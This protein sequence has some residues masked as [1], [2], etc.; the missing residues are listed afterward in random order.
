MVAAWIVVAVLV[1]LAALQLA[2]ACGL[3]W[4]AFAWGG[5]HE[6][7]PTPLRIA[8]ACTIPVYAVMAVVV[9]DR[10]GEIDVLPEAAADVGAWV[11]FGFAALSVAVN[12]MSRST[13]E[14]VTMTPLSVVLAV[15]SLLV[16]TA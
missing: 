14:R 1:L 15:A 16:A 2:L 5:Q 9:L 4:G 7:L 11:V 13:K 6:T 10:A 3:P 8:S 12:A